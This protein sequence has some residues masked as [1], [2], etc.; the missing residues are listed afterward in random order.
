M[1]IKNDNN[2]GARYL[3]MLG[4]LGMLTALAPVVNNMFSPAMPAIM[5][6]FGV[7]KASVQ[8]GLTACMIGLAV[9]QLVLGPLSD[10]YGR[11]PVLLISMGA[12]VVCSAVLVVCSSLS[13]FIALRLLQGLSASGGIVISRS[14]A[15]DVASDRA[16]LRMLAVINVINGVMPIVTPV[17]G[18]SA[19]AA[20][21]WQG[22]MACMAVVGVVLALGCLTLRETLPS[23]RRVRKAWIARPYITLLTRKSFVSTVLHQGGALGVLFGNIA[24]TPFLVGHYGMAPSMTGVL[25]AVNGVFTALGAGLAGAMRDARRGV[26]LTSVGLPVLALLLVSSVLWLDNVWA[27]EAV[28][29]AMLALVGVTLTS[30]S[31]RAM[32]V[33]RDQAGTGSAL[34]GAIGFVMGAIVAPLIGVG[35]LLWAVAATM[36]AMALWAASWGWVSVKS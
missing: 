21:G 15:T 34:L 25:L 28:M 18:A 22:V 30:S 12:F 33:A 20:W 29:C 5:A 14:M 11:R 8:M 32:D 9:G 16:L 31:T 27:Y 36:L 2:G 6:A 23:E 24:A 35:S 26:A 4:L 1:E 3:V 17:A 10:R 19:C 13:W 7:S